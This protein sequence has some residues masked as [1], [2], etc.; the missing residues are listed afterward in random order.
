MYIIVKE[1]AMIRS[2]DVRDGD[3]IGLTVKIV[4]TWVPA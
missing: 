1:F 2:L 4:W 3:Y